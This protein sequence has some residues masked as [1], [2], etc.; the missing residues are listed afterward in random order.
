MEGWVVA[1][2][3][4]E[5]LANGIVDR[6]FTSQL[7]V[8]SDDEFS[9][10]QPAPSYANDVGQSQ[11][12]GGSLQE[13]AFSATQVVRRP[14]LTPSM[15]RPSLGSTGTRQ[16]KGINGAV[17]SP[18]GNSVAFIALNDLWVMKIGQ[19]PVRLTNDID[20]DVDPSLE[21]FPVGL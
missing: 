2:P 3:A 4:S 17:V 7:T 15:Y 19:A 13:I 14:K 21:P 18:D 1:Q 5:A 10:G 8:L 6:S 11:P 20:R 12:V 9:R 16:V